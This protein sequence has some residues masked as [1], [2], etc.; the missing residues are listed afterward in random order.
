M[1]VA[2]TSGTRLRAGSS[3]SPKIFNLIDTSDEKG[4]IL[5]VNPDAN[6]GI[7]VSGKYNQVTIGEGVTFDGNCVALLS[8]NQT[9]TVNGTINGGNDFAVATNGSTT[10]DLISLPMVSIIT[11]AKSRNS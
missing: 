7:Q 10:T 1:S 4:G 5:K 8:E 9:L 2:V 3:S 6:I 11:K